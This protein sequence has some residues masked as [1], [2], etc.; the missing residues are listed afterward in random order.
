M[1]PRRIIHIDRN[2]EKETWITFCG[3]VEDVEE[4]PTLETGAVVIEDYP[5]Y[6]LSEG[7]YY[8]PKCLASERL[9]LEVLKYT[10]L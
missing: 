1:R 10:E 5:E 3:E 4:W 9:P 6:V 7:D 8:C 2:I